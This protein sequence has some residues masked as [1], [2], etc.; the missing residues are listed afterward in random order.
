MK[1]PTEGTSTVEKASGGAAVVEE[2]QGTVETAETER[3]EAAERKRRETDEARERRDAERED[4]AK[5]RD[6]AA[7][8]AAA[9]EP[10]QPT[11]DEGDLAQPR[12]ATA[13]ARGST[14]TT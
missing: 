14:S 6:E 10:H 8:R 5:A 4:R 2:L 7:E 13:S 1:A 3:A 11:E 12:E 9:G